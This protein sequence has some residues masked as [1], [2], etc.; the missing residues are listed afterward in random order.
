M[1][2]GASPAIEG[3]APVTFVQLDDDI[4]LEYQYDDDSVTNLIHQNKELKSKIYE[5]ERELINRDLIEFTSQ[6][7]DKKIVPLN[8]KNSTKELL[9]LAY[10]ID[11]NSNNEYNL[12]DRLKSFFHKLQFN[13]LQK[14][15]ATNSTT[16]KFGELTNA[17]YLLEDREKLHH[18]IL[19][20]MEQN[21][22]ISYNQALNNLIKNKQ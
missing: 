10:D 1:L 3:L 22:E 15:F 6:L 16:K 21:P 14:E 4:D 2:G 19:E 12:L 11:R 8:Q 20:Y 17:K 13:S 9:E 18:T 7:V 5:Y